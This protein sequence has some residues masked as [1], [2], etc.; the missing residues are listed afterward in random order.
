MYSKIVNP[1]TGRKV[2]V[3]SRLGKSIIRKYLNVL[4][5][6]TKGHY[7]S[8]GRVGKKV[9][10]KKIKAERERQRVAETLVNERR[11]DMERQ[12]QEVG[13]AAAPVSISL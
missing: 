9:H 8:R 2:S 4:S 6:G 5:G 13:S 1:K 11:R 10:Q 3:T 7:P 12:E